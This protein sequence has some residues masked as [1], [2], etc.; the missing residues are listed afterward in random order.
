[1]FISEQSDHLSTLASPSHRSP[2]ST[3]KLLSSINYT[4]NLFLVECVWVVVV[5]GS[6]KTTDRVQ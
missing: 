2:K 5:V 1:M 4:Y 6:Q 3:L